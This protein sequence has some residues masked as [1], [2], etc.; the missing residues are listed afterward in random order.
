MRKGAM[1]IRSRSLARL[2][3]GLAAFT[4]LTAVDSAHADGRYEVAYLGAVRGDMQVE[5]SGDRRI[6]RFRYADRGR[7]PDLRSETRFDAAFLPVATTITGFNY[8]RSPVDERFA[9]DGLTG[10]WTSAV[11]R[12]TT[13]AAGYY[14]PQEATPDAM[15]ALARALLAAPDGTLALLPSGTARIER[16]TDQPVTLDGNAQTATLYFLHGLDFGP[17]PVWLDGARN[18]VL[19]SGSGIATRLTTLGPEDEAALRR[20]QREAVEAREQ[21][22]AR[23]LTR[24]PD[25]PV[26][27]RNVAIYDAADRAR[28]DG[29]TVIVRDDRI[30]W[31]GPAADAVITADAQVIEG[32]GRTLIPGLF[33][34]HVHL[35]RETDGLLAIA[36]GVTSTR[37]L[38][39]D[40][41]RLGELRAGWD[42]GRA[43][44]PRVV[45]AAAMMDGPGP[46][47]GPT[48]LY[49][50]TREQA[51]A[52]VDRVVARGGYQ[53]IKLYSSVDPALVPVLAAE[54]HRRGLRVQGHVPGGMTM[55]QAIRA[56][57][58]EVNHA[59]FWMLGLMGPE[60]VAQTNTPVR[61]TAI[62]ERGRDL[63]LASPQV[64]HLIDL[65]V[66]R[67][68]VLDPTLTVFE[69]FLT[70][71]PGQPAPS[72]ATIAARM[73]SPLVR[74]LAGGGFART[75]ADRTRNRESMARLG[76]FLALFH[77][78]GATMVAGSDAAVGP[79]ALP[80]ELELY[81]AAGLSPSEALHMA[82]LGAARLAGVGD[83][84]GS[85]EPGKL[86]DLVLIDGD[87]TQ[88]IGDLRN[89]AIVMKGG[90]LFDPES[91]FQAAGMRPAR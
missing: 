13:G 20:R 37:D 4:L 18:L 7:G 81:V 52:I 83:R 9:R 75:E 10:H 3:A 77:R 49:V 73:P 25:G 84:L 55:E 85:I 56:G 41:T 33:D 91:L 78:A 12:G 36:S 50:S 8:F 66:A 69:D 74:A 27:F 29:R 31:V 39:N 89:T 64:R 6:V 11:D 51:I 22:L 14:W 1:T 38:A 40:F 59:N 67:G 35:A 45:A 63:D 16:A 28:R 79:L 24:R 76:Q 88:R 70:A 86:A 87:P 57:Y 26:V 5:T 54:A 65:V 21:R 90:L 62:G 47:A 82:T 17:V 44:G 48:D 80:H 61:L 42:A 2:L 60:I 19:D 30:A 43:I 32:A 71:A 72:I 53:G 46:L 34:M 68:T 15:A 58:D 23:D